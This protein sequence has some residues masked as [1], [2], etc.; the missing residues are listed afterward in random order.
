MKAHAEVFHMLK[1]PRKLSFEP[2]LGVVSLELTIGE[3]ILKFVVSPVLAVIIDQFSTK[4]EH[5]AAY[6]ARA[7]NVPLDLLLRKCGPP[8]PSLLRKWGPPSALA[9]VVRPD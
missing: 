5:T 8:P 6:L 1:N 3:H 4:A 2:A 7:C 9:V